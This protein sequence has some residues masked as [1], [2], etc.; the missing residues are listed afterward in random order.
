MFSFTLMKNHLP[1]LLSEDWQGAGPKVVVGERSVQGH[2]GRAF[3]RRRFKADIPNYD[4]THLFI[5]LTSLSSQLADS[6]KIKNNLNFWNIY[7]SQGNGNQ[8]TRYTLTLHSRSIPTYQTHIYQL[9]LV[10][11]DANKNSVCA[12]CLY[13]EYSFSSALCHRVSKIWKLPL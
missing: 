4:P 3:R 12:Y 8:D 1:L 5:Q 11:L 9:I 13:V 10:I 7:N 6:L 2:S